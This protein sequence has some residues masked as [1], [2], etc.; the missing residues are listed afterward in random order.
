MDYT[1]YISSVIYSAGLAL[2]LAWIFRRMNVQ[3]AMDGLK[4]GLYMGITL[5]LFYNIMMNLFSMRPYP[6][7]W[8]DGGAGI[9]M[10]AISGLILGGWRKY[11]STPSA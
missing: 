1:S 10:F 9:I 2:V 6:L 4:T 5:S 11:E 3:S 7:S 8:I